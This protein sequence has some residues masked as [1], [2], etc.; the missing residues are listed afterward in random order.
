M[1]P[2]SDS[3]KQK[4][5]NNLALIRKLAGWTSADLG[6][7]IGVTKQTI[8][9][10]ENNRTPM[11]K[12][13]YIAIRAMID[14]EISSNKDTT[15]LAQVVHLLLDADDISEDDQQKLDTTMAYVSGAKEKGLNSAAIVAG[16]T[17]LFAALGL[18]VPSLTTILTATATTPLWLDA[19]S[20]AKKMNSNSHSRK[21]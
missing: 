13:Q 2:Y 21:G 10:L 8:S 3:D 9:N 4:L 19:I 16:M 7:L 18:M 17:A 12:T 1:K 15:A 5:Q 11:T 14:Y 20:T 6:E